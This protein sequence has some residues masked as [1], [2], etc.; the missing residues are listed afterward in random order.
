MGI[1]KLKRTHKC[2]NLVETAG[3]DYCRVDAPNDGKTEET[4]ESELI[5]P[6]H[7]VVCPGTLSSSESFG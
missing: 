3:Q 2:D 4:D 6:S 1:C 7:T 5:A